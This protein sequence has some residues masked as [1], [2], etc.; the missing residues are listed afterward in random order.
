MAVFGRAAYCTYDFATAENHCY[1]AIYKAKKKQH[2]IVCNALFLLAKIEMM[3]G[4]FNAAV[5]HLKKIDAYIVE[6]KAICLRETAGFV[7]SW[8]YL[9]MGEADKVHRWDADAGNI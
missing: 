8:V 6:Q 7:Q 2:D 4:K 9:T 3:R 5:E 1:R